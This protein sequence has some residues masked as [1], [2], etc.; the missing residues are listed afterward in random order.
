MHYIKK[1][2]T[3]HLEHFIENSINLKMNEH[4]CMFNMDYNP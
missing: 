2:T 4:L 3:L 1:K